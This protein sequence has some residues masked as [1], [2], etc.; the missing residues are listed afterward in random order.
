MNLKHTLKVAVGNLTNS[1]L[2]TVLAMLGVLVGTASVVAMV[3]SGQL[4]TAQALAQFKVLGTNLLAVTLY[5]SETGATP[6]PNTQLS[7]YQAME[8]RRVSKDLEIVAPYTTLFE[9]MSFEGKTINAGIVG[10]TTDLQQAI[11]IKMAKGRFVS[12][13][14]QYSFFCVLGDDLYQTIQK[15]SP[16][17]PIGKQI[18]VGKNYFTIIGV[19]QKWPQNSFFNQDVNDSLFVPIKT[20]SVMSKYA[21]INNIVF[22]LEKNSNIDQIESKIKKYINSVSSG[23]KLFFRS[24]KQIIKS[25]TKQRQIMTIFLGLIGGIS[26]LVGGIGVMNIMLVSVIERRR[27]IGIRRAI[28]ARQRDI[29]MMFLI[30]SVILAL[31]GGTIGVVVGIG[32][33]FIIAEYAHWHFVFFILPPVIGFSVSVLVG[34]FF[35]FY[36]AVQASRLDPIETL[37]SE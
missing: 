26:L 9:Q 6:S 34:V 35:G 12:I 14:D 13:L 4:A 2:R 7:L 37:R 28:G 17:N 18:L 22:R 8:M 30:E 25:M 33:S 3:S 36:P 5:Q 11:R 21:H 31:L 19:A 32:I 15:V 29:Q 1:K 16:G 24:A 27:E 10:A 20:S 23:K